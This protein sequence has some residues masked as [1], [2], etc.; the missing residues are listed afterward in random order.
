MSKTCFLFV[1]QTGLMG[2]G[3]R[4][5]RR[6]L[7]HSSVVNGPGGY[8]P[9]GFPSRRVSLL[10][11]AC[12]ESTGKYRLSLSRYYYFG[13]GDI[14]SFWLSSLPPPD[15]HEVGLSTK[16]ASPCSGRA[17]A[18]CSL[19]EAATAVAEFFLTV[20]IDCY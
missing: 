20:F 18:C 16:L 6:R 8:D 9:D 3:L 17:W 12:R 7:T 10:R 15:A 19:S 5:K 2:W 14:S 11:E 13:M 1:R 4:H